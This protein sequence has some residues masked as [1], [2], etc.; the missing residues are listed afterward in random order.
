MS[1]NLSLEPKATL[2]IYYLVNE[3]IQVQHTSTQLLCRQIYNIEQTI[4]LTR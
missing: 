4:E 3:L 1:M 2:Y